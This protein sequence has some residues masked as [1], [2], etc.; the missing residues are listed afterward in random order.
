MESRNSLKPYAET[1]NRP[2]STRDLPQPPRKAPGQ[3]YA[4]ELPQQRG[5]RRALEHEGELPSG[6]TGGLSRHKRSPLRRRPQPPMRH[7]TRAYLENAERNARLP[8]REL[9][10]YISRRIASSSRSRRNCTQA[11]TR[12][13]PADRR[14]TS[15]P[16]AKGHA[17][18]TRPPAPSTSPTC[19]T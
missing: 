3:M 2:T 15:R 9:Y 10:A 7:A 8:A 16:P 1:P 13:R 14:H 6:E 11:K 4:A 5:L 18:R 12:R 19:H 17:A